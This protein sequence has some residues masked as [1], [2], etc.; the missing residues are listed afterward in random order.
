LFGY[1]QERAALQKN[2]E[3]EWLCNSPNVINCCQFRI[4]W[5]IVAT[6]KLCGMNN[7]MEYQLFS[8]QTLGTDIIAI[9]NKFIF[10]WFFNVP[11]QTK[12]SMVRDKLLIM[13]EKTIALSFP[14]TFQGVF[15]YGWMGSMWWLLSR[16]I[17]VSMHIMSAIF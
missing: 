16:E 1:V 7:S 15:A 12:G 17:K 5:F 2:W 3:I 10:I 4:E 8:L 11:E 9:Y 13:M 14:K 6:F